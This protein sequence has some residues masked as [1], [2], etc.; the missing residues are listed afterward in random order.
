MWTIGKKRVQIFQALYNILNQ[1]PGSR[2]GICAYKY[3]QANLLS[4][5]FKVLTNIPRYSFYW[6][7][8]P[9]YRA[10]Y[11]LISLFQLRSKHRCTSWKIEETLLPHSWFRHHQEYTRRRISYIIDIAIEDVL[12]LLI[13]G[14]FYIHLNLV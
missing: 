3:H 12:H 10:Q 9:I 13:V 8:P 7:K 6:K 14:A 1:G 4:N 5:I 2:L 11:I